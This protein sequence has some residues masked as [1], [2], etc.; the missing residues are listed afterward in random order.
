MP[1][2]VNWLVEI[3]VW[4]ASRTAH[5]PRGRGKAC[6]GGW[7]TSL[8]AFLACVLVVREDA[9]ELL[10]RA[11]IKL[12]EDLAQ[13]ILDCARADEQLTADLWV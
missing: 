13:V 12:A 10:T 7:A 6:P 4:K 1:P 8:S 11:D 2:F 5:F 3:K 9:I